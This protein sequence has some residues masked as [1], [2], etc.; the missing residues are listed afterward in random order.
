MTA[1]VDILIFQFSLFFF[2]FFICSFFIHLQQ[3]FGEIWKEKNLDILASCQLQVL[4]VWTFWTWG[5]VRMSNPLS[6]PLALL[7]HVLFDLATTQ[8]LENFASGRINW[9]GGTLPT[10]SNVCLHSILAKKSVKLNIPSTL[11]F[12]VQFSS[13]LL[14]LWFK[15][16]PNS[17]CDIELGS[18]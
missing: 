15:A 11:N 17:P 13:F 12:P 3:Y 8:F 18:R 4:S 1:D 9:E 10:I 14:F 6:S 7:A 16:S 2:S 5:E